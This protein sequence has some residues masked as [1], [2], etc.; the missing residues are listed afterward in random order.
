MVRLSYNQQRLLNVLPEEIEQ[1]EAKI[2][3]TEQALS[4]SNLY[5]QNPEEFGR[6]SKE[7]EELNRQKEDKENMWLELQ[8]LKE[9]L[10]QSSN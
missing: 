6:L 1:L 5:L 7:L 9:S 3:Q 2:Y 10:E 4:D 8:M